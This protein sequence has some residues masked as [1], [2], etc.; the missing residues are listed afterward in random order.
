MLISVTVGDPHFTGKAAARGHALTTQN[1]LLCG[2]RVETEHERANT[3]RTLPCWAAVHS[4]LMLV[5]VLF[6]E[7]IIKRSYADSWPAT[8]I[9][10]GG[11]GGRRSHLGSK[12]SATFVDCT[13]AA[14][15]SSSSTELDSMVSDK[16]CHNELSPRHSKTAIPQKWEAASEETSGLVLLS[17]FADGERGFVAFAARIAT[18]LDCSVEQFV[19]FAAA[20]TEGSDSKQLGQF[21]AVWQFSLASRFAAATTNS[22]SS[23]LLAFA[24]ATFC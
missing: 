1:K 19:A 17:A 15:H 5:Q 20:L 12:S 3:S 14:E 8:P 24:H 11:S 10:G 21:I 2:E 4:A 23:T 7:R 13:M 6:D 16:I 18:L 22:G 9:I